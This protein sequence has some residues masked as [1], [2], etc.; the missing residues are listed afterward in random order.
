MIVIDPFKPP[1]EHLYNAEYEH[2]KEVFGHK[3]A[4]DFI[5]RQ[6]KDSFTKDEMIAWFEPSTNKGSLTP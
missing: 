2:K 6:K 5:M 4:K 3:V 1:D